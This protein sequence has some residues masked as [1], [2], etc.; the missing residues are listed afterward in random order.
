MLQS[1]YY[2][3]LRK[4]EVILSVNLLKI[5][6]T[7]CLIETIVLLQVKSYQSLSGAMC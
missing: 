3:F 6:L 2:G 7:E 5:K 1:R 4:M